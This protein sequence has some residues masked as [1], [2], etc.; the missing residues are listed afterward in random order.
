[1]S[2]QSDTSQSKFDEWEGDALRRRRYAAFLTDYIK[3]KSFDAKTGKAKSF[4]MAIDD[5]WGKGKTF[6]VKK[7][8]ED[9][10][11]QEPPIRSIYFDAWEADC[12]SDPLI[13]FIA[14]LQE[15]IENFL[16]V[17][18]KIVEL[19]T[20]GK[21]Q[22]QKTFIKI[23]KAFWPA[24]KLLAGNFAKHV[25]GTS[26]DEF[27]ELGVGEEDQNGSR[28][29]IDK[30]LDRF[31]VQAIEEQGNKRQ[32]IREFKSEIEQTLQS[33]DGK[34][35][36]L[37]I[38]VFVDELDRSRPN[39]AIELLEGIKHLFDIP[40]LCFVISTNINQLAE[41][42]RGGYGGD[43]D[44]RRYLDR[45]FH[46]RYA[47]PKPTT[48]QYCQQ[49]ANQFD[50]N[51]KDVDF[52]IP[53]AAGSFKYQPNA[54]SAFSWVAS[55]FELDLR[56]QERVF[57][58]VIDAFA[59]LEPGTRFQ[60]LF[61]TIIC[62]IRYRDVGTFDELEVPGIQGERLNELLDP[63][64]VSDPQLEF[65]NRDR[66][67]NLDGKAR[68]VTLKSVFVQYLR[69][70]GKTPAEAYEYA[71][72]NNENIYPKSVLRFVQAE[73]NGQYASVGGGVS[74]QFYFPLVRSAGY[75]GY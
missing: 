36:Q 31:F 25:T 71:F 75:L 9:L 67:G 18:D 14:E 56:S 7:W 43:F 46:T 41:T 6:F 58:M 61:M 24:T 45:L 73:K 2:K 35:L 64:F 10:L 37:P 3:R 12:I 29:A 4:V 57:N 1:M 50:W 30:G 69:I 48:E 20:I 15:G 42:V 51:R 55:V 26:L 32:V 47:L 62:T 13:A 66:F 52:G 11:L 63:L 27:L 74:L 22:L 19:P 21:Q 54:G 65:H 68:S 53:A 33:L 34:H 28:D 49:L 70:L 39:F 40:G 38:V 17:P 16:P 8:A 60:F 5:E 59:G 44:G 23:R 72:A